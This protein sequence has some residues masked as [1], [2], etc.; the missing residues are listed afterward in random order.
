MTA[1]ASESIWTAVG[2]CGQAIFGLRFV[3]QW[4]ATERQKRSVIPLAFWYLSLLGTVILLSYAIYLVN[5]VFI[6]GFSL[7]MLI[8]LRNLYFIHFRRR[9]A[10]EGSAPPQG[11]DGPTEES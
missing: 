8:Y 10:P 7:N 5:W 1:A 11:P 4:I 6:A 3:V 2:F 9:P